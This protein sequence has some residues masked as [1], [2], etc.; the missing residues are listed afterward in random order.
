MR[1]HLYICW[2]YSDPLHST[3]LKHLGSNYSLESSWVWRYKH[4]TPV[5]REFLSFLS[6]DPLN[7]CQVGW[8]VLLHSYFQI[9]PEMLGWIQVRALA[10]H[11]RTFRDLSWSHS[12]VVLA[13]CLGLLSCWK[14]K[15][16]PSLRSWA[17]CS[18]FSSRISLYFAPF[19]F[20]RSWLV[21]QSLPLKNFPT[22][23][24]HHHL[25][26]P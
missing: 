16:C 25:A 12:Y 5:F 10:G 18:R 13:V 23:W 20:A 22:A 11:S 2:V 17:L 8:R 3:L 4:G 14:V 7:F 1:G 6:A 21:S 24:R 9:S 26:S 15:L 19:I